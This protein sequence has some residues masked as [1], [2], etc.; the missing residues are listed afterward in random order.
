MKSYRTQAEVDA[1]IVDNTLNINESVEFKF[2]LVIKAHIIVKGNIT[3]RNINALNINAQD[4]N[5]GNIN[6]EDINAQDITAQDINAEDINAWNINALNIN[7][8]NISFYAVCF[9]YVSLKCKSIIGR[10]IRSK[11]FCLDKEVEVCGD[12]EKIK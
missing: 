3:A 9:A 11:Y 12:K 10:K 4:I 6:A 1:D 7:A 5:A 8:R 2:D